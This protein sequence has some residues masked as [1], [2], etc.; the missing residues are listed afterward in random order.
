MNFSRQFF[1]SHKAK[2]CPS[3]NISSV[4]N[5]EQ[6]SKMN[7]LISC[8]ASLYH[9][10]SHIMSVKDIYLSVGTLISFS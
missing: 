4:T 1:P 8:K 7:C 6:F 2:L 3:K 10:M 5:N 9:K